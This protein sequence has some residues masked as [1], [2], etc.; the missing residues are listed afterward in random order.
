MTEEKSDGVRG[1]QS[2]RRALGLLRSVATKSDCGVKL[3]QVVK[4]SGLDRATV[5]RLLSCLVD[6]GFVQRDDE[7]FY[8]LGPQAVV[9]GSLMPEATPLI[10]MFR[11]AMK[12]MARIAEDSVFLMIRYGDMVQCDHRELGGVL[13][14]RLTTVSGQRRLLGTGT[15][16]VAILGLMETEEIQKIW[17][18]HA[19]EYDA[20]GITQERLLA[21]AHAVRLRRVAITFD[22]IE[23]GV[24]GI[25]MAFR[26][27]NH[28]MGALSIGT[29]TTR[30]GPERQYELSELLKTELDALELFER[31]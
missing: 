18:R 14:G 21:M 6:E 26:I 7:G 13:G 24:A 3:A 17:A 20:L 11:P 8:R 23:S 22:S 1:T 29:H 10:T 25:G 12:R 31:S 15:G 30:L 4:E 19:R 28:A 9:L 5:Y 2:V 16:S 27:G